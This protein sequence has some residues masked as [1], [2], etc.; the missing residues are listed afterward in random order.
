MNVI[1]LTE[2]KRLM[3]LLDQAELRTSYALEAAEVARRHPATKKERV[4]LGRSVMNHKR[5]AMH[6]EDAREILRPF[7][8]K[9]K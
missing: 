7:T 4:A 6:L 3:K 2:A 1:K 9:Q 8:I 5:A